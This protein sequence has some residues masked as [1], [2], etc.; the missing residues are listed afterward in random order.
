MSMH[1]RAGDWYIVK[2]LAYGFRVSGVV[3]GIIVDVLSYDGHGLH[4]KDLDDNHYIFS[5][6][7]FDVVFIEKECKQ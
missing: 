5:A 4:C 2:K 6:N 7:N 3:D 1:F